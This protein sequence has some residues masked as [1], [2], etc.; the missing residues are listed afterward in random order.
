MKAI[1]WAITATILVLSNAAALA[2]TYT[3]G[4]VSIIDPW[5]RE[6]PPGVSRGV[7]YMM[8][9]NHGDSVVTLTGAKTTRAGDVTL[10]QS[11][12]KGDLVT[13]EYVEGGLTI[14]AGETVALEPRGYHF[15]LDDLDRALVRNESVAMTVFFDGADAVDIN[16]R[17][18]SLG[19]MDHMDH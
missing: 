4:A 19:D 11:R 6:T 9:T 17:V 14:A 12:M 5:S 16:V 18:K 8:I 13:M 1:V 10:H 15:M 2:E 3:R 7:A